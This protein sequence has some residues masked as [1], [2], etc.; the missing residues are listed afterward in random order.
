MKDKFTKLFKGEVRSID[1]ENKTVEA[2]ISD[3]T[4]DRYDEVVA[5]SAWKRGLSNYKKHPVFLSSHDYSD[6]MSQ[7]G[8][9]EDVWVEDNQLIARFKYFTD[10]GNPSA[11]WAFTLAKN[12]AAAFSVG[13]IGK[14]S[15]M[16]SEDI[17]KILG[18]GLKRYPWRVFT[19][20]ELLEVS[21]VT[22]PANPAALQKSVDN[23]DADPIIK[24]IAGHVLKTLSKKEM[25]GVDSD[26][27]AQVA[28]EAKEAKE[29]VALELKEAEEKAAE[30]KER[31]E[32]E[33]KEA[34]ES[35]IE[36]LTVLKEELTV[37]KSETISAM[38]ASIDK[39][40][41]ERIE[42]AVKAIVSF[43]AEEKNLEDDNDDNDDS[44]AQAEALAIAEKEADD[45]KAV[46]KEAEEKTYLEGILKDISDTNKVLK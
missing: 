16:E 40:F 4:I 12:G 33:A 34:A 6:V 14:E 21:H 29:K 22:V 27:E 46:D 36:E 30:L 42:K 25:E 23:T 32:K 38:I 13:F 1:E 5:M 24:S 17:I 31:E 41:K 10:Q 7:L 37:L 28:K 11:D 44:E 39:S 3:E 15:V 35:L 9:A 45:K 19:E 43:K 18:D 2:V 26:I 20:V 8:V